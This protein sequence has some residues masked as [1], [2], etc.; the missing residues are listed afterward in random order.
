VGRTGAGKSSLYQL[1]SGFRSPSEGVILIDNHDITKIPLNKLRSE[2][3]VV[4]QQPFVLS[5]ETIRKNLDPNSEYSDKELDKALNDA[6]FF[7]FAE[8]VRQGNDPEDSF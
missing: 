5:C 7:H 1:L 6:A 8:T 3:N 4:L 2:V